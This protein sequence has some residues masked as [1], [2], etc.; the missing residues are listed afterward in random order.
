M[1]PVI[2]GA[3]DRIE[4]YETDTTRR[5]LFARAV[6]AL[7][8]A[9]VLRTT[10]GTVTL[11]SQPLGPSHDLCA[12]EAHFDQPS[13]ASCS[14]TLIDD[15]LVLT[16]GHC[17]DA[18]AC[19]EQRYVFG[20]Y[21]DAADT[22]HTIDASE[23]Y[24]CADVVAYSGPGDDDFAI[25]ELDAAPPGP[26][27]E[28]RLDAVVV[29]ESASL[30]GFPLGLPMKVV[31]MGPVTRLGR[32]EIFYARLDAHPGNSGSGVFDAE[33]RVIGELTNG[34]VDAFVAAGDCQR[35]RVIGEDTTNTETIRSVAAAVEALC[36]GGYASERLCGTS[37]GDGVCA[38][39]ELCP[40]DCPAETDA[41]TI[42][43]PDA[44]VVRTDVGPPRVDAGAA[45]PSSGG[46]ACRSRAASP[47]PGA[48]VLVLLAV[49]A[50]LRRGRVTARARSR[51]C[52]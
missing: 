32:G 28:V 18:I 22:L 39:G 1:E 49:G 48:A 20:W 26:P 6:P 33:M 7:V 35:L 37:C 36:A 34:P 44:A 41:G 10:G 8:H 12:G 19:D 51:R 16:A 47:T 3:D 30:A 4:L 31:E 21:Y 23:V 14:A 38:T 27:A 17:V 40:A 11:R 5:E 52:S 50:A 15:R 42:E 43:L 29:G 46:C 9:N 45:A 13:A 25:V 2:F 24:A